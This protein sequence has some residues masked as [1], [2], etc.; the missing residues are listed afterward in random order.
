MANT[1]IT[2]ILA[3][4][5]TPRDNHFLSCYCHFVIL[6]S[7]CDMIFNVDHSKTLPEQNNKTAS[8]HETMHKSLQ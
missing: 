5:N 2:I 1:T 8:N 7:A 3:S 6:N 4:P